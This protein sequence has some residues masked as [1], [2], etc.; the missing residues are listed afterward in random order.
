VAAGIVP[1]A[2]GTDT[3]G[4]VRVPAAFCGLF[5][6]RL[7]PGDPFV[8][9]AFPLAPSFDTAGWFTANAADMRATIAAL[10]GSDSSHGTPRG[11]SVDMPGLDPDVA[12]SFRAAAARLTNRADATTADTLLTGFGSA[13]E[14]YSTI[15]AAEAW[16]VHAPWAERFRD[17]YDPT[18]WER[19]ARG[20][21][22][23]PEAIAAAREEC[24]KIWAL[25]AGF[26][27]AYDYLVLPASPFGAPT[28]HGCTL[29]NRRRI[30]ALTAPASIG[31]LPVLTVPFNLPSGLTGGLQIIVRDPSSAVVDWV[32]AG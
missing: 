15:V 7:T 27:S 6:F 28:K 21:T 30:L 23:P 32:L 12:A 18:V 13:L 25:W 14:T 10:V 8:H 2:I 9:D 11:C 31:G 29:E 24:A 3:G 22:I 19:I 20:R 5:G 4:S 1:L 17:R 16:S 26:F